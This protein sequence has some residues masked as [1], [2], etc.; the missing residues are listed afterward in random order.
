MRR[1]LAPAVACCWLRGGGDRV[2]MVTMS[3]APAAAFAAAGSGHPHRPASRRPITGAG[4]QHSRARTRRLAPQ[5]GWRWLLRVPQDLP[6]ANVIPPGWVFAVGDRCR[7][8]GAIWVVHY[9]TGMAAE[10]A[11][12]CGGWVYA[13]ACACSAGSLRATGRSCCSQLP[14]TV[15]LVVS[16]TRAGLP[17]YEAFRAIADEMPSPTRDEFVRVNNEMALGVAAEDALLSMHQRTG[18]TEYAIFAVTIGVQARSGGRLAETIQNLAETVRERLAIAAR[19]A[20]AG[21]RGKDFRDHHGRAAGPRRR[22]VELR[23]AGAS[24]AAVHRSAR[25]PDVHGRRGHAVPRRG[26]DAPTDQGS[27]HGLNDP[28]TILAVVFAAGAMMLAAGALVLTLRG[29]AARSLEQRVI[30]VS[31]GSAIDQVRTD[32]SRV[33]V[34]AAPAGL[35][36]RRRCAAAPASTPN[37]TSWRSRA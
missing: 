15:Q 4:P 29:L 2:V 12:R 28:I 13:C 33:G 32:A 30:A 22:I 27:D 9:L 17:V 11:R 14:D 18:V 1:R 16:A 31:S 36:R 21:G 25:R 35:D 10:H 34:A 5:P 7:G 37:A 3:R 20:G 8:F 19:R 23:A 24:D 26:H 6:L